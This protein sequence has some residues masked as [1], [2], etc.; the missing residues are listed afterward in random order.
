M[1]L[2]PEQL[3]EITTM[4]SLFFSHEQIALNLELDPD[5]FYTQLQIK[6]SPIFKAYFSGRLQ[7]EIQLRQSILQSASFGSNPAQQVMLSFKSES[8]LL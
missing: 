1:L 3:S 4:A 8:E 2:T 6:S 7:T 5:D